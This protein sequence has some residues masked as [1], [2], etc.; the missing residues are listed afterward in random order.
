[1]AC[2]MLHAIHHCLLKFSDRRNWR[3]RNYRRRFYLFIT[4]C[5][6]SSG[7]VQLAFHRNFSQTFNLRPCNTMNKEPTLDW[8]WLHAVWTH[9]GCRSTFEAEIRS[10]SIIIPPTPLH[11]ALFLSPINI[12]PLNISQLPD[13]SFIQRMNCT[14]VKHLPFSALFLN[15]LNLCSPWFVYNLGTLLTA[16]HF[17][18][19]TG[20][21]APGL[22]NNSIYDVTT[23]I[24][25][26]KSTPFIKHSKLIYSYV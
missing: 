5:L 17:S 11:F 16:L 3:C 14:R 22:T 13:I 26:Y 8:A 25:F 10:R 7:C 20:F 9:R 12:S 2:V 1:M 24:V 6:R 19:M 18:G 23:R 15:L 4:V 21:S